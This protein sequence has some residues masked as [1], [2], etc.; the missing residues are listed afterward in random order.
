MDSTV[1]QSQDAGVRLAAGWSGMHH[2]RVPACAGLVV[3]VLEDVTAPAAELATGLEADRDAAAD[4][5]VSL[6][7]LED[8]TEAV[9]LTETRSVILDR[10]SRTALPMAVTRYYVPAPTTLSTTAMLT[11][12]SPLGGHLPAVTE[13]FARSAG[14]FAFQSTR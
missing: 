6:V 3:Q 12:T 1:K 4:R 8:G 14:T 13:V 11:F 2:G 5:A 7:A 9:R 10:R